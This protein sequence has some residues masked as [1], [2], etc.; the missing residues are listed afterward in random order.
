MDAGLSATDL[1]IQQDM[2]VGI[3]TARGLGAGIGL[4]ERIDLA[5]GD[6]LRLFPG[7]D[8]AFLFVRPVELPHGKAGA[9]QDD[10]HRCDVGQP[11][12]NKG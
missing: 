2:P 12:K 5:E 3:E 9:H 7:L 10:E 4:L 11:A 1:V 6:R 8:K